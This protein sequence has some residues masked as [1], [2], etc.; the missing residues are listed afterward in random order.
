MLKKLA[1]VSSNFTWNLKSL[2]FYLLAEVLST[3]HMFPLPYAGVDH[4]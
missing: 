2:Y 4:I 1:A 3:E